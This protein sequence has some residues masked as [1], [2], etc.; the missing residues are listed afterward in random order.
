MTFESLSDLVSF[1]QQF[2]LFDQKLRG[3]VFSVLM[4]MAA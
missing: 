4:G 3:T 2:F 1:A